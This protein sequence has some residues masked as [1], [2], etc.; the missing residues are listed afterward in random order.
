MGKISTNL[1]VA[2]FAF[3][4]GLA[5]ASAFNKFN[6]DDQAHAMQSVHSDAMGN[7]RSMQ[8]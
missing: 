3:L 4:I 8:D 5:S 2:V 7:V 1:I 6:T